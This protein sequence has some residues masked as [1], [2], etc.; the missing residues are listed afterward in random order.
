VSLKK[1]PLRM[2]IGCLEMKEKKE[3]LRLT[4]DKEGHILLDHRGKTLGRGAYICKDRSCFQQILKRK[5]LEKVF[6]EQ[7]QETLVDA[8]ERELEDLN[9]S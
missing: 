8:I 3:L 1:K 2:C 9:G 5:K 6:K 4:K 7:M